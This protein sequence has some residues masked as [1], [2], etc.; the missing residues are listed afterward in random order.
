MVSRIFFVELGVLRTIC[1]RESPSA[2][3]K[4]RASFWRRWSRCSRNA[5]GDLKATLKYLL[6]WTD[7]S[8]RVF[9]LATATSTWKLLG[10][11]VV[12]DYERSLMQKKN[13]RYDDR[14][15]ASRTR[16]E[17]LLSVT[18]YFGDNA[19]G[20]DTAPVHARV[21]GC[22]MR[23]G[24]VGSCP[25]DPQA[26][27]TGDTCGSS[28]HAARKALG[29]NGRMAESTEWKVVGQTISKMSSGSR[30]GYD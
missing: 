25:R 10:D 17:S 21:C 8:K 2:R 15:N 19:I 5:L 18:R 12:L 23:T 4:R 14:L 22:E 7:H 6:S 11:G 3:P 9:I 29:R 24:L 1:C 28:C 16:L 13:K 26:H 20:S 30:E 27:S